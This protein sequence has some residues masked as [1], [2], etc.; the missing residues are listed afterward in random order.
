MHLKNKSATIY[1]KLRFSIKSPYWRC[2]VYEYLR[3]E[4]ALL[5]RFLTNFM[6]TCKLLGCLVRIFHHPMTQ[7]SDVV[8]TK[9]CNIRS[10][11]LEAIK[12]RYLYVFK[13]HMKSLKNMCT[14]K[15][16][17]LGPVDGRC[18]HRILR[19][20]PGWFSR[21]NRGRWRIRHSLPNLPL[22]HQIYLSNKLF[23]MYHQ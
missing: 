10:L 16:E 22:Q 17:C 21:V 1:F 12:V 6:D 5:Q 19:P 2:F 23:Q 8:V 13:I 11:K 15:E 20:M 9:K 14:D 3:V 7:V 4:H 18:R